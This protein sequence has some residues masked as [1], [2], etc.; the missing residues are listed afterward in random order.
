MRSLV[1]HVG[2]QGG[3][4]TPSKCKSSQHAL[5]ELRMLLSLIIS[6]CVICNLGRFNLPMSLRSKASLFVAC[7]LDKAILFH[8]LNDILF[9][10]NL[11]LH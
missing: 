3:L 7:V 2:P 9:K 10:N 4:Q 8:F 1:G 5:V 6:I 11:K